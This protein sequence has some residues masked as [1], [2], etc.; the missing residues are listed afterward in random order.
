MKKKTWLSAAR[1]RVLAAPVTTTLAGSGAALLLAAACSG[2]PVVPDVVPA[3]TG[4]VSVDVAFGH[5]LMQPATASFHVWVLAPKE[6]FSASCSKL[7]ADEVDPYDKELE[8]LADEV[9]TDIQAAIEFSS[10]VGEGVVYVEGVNFS[11]EAVFA[12]CDSITVE[13]E[14]GASAEVTLI[15]AGSYD[16]DAAETEDGSPCDDGEFCTTGETCD[17]G[18]CGDGSARDCSTLAGDCSAG[19]CSESDGCMFEPQP[20]DTVCDDGLVCTA[21]DAC[22]DGQCIGAEV[23]CTG[24]VCGGAYCDEVSGGCVDGG[25]IP[26]GTPCDD[27]NVCTSASSCN[28]GT[29]NAQ[30]D[31]VLC[32][33]SDCAPDSDCDTGTGCA[34]NAAAATARLGYSCNDNPCMDYQYNYYPP[35]YGGEPS[36][37]YYATC[38]GLGTCV[39]GVPLPSGTTCNL[40]CQTGTCDGSGTC[41]ITGNRTDSTSCMGAHPTYSGTYYGQCMAGVCIY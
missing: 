32:P 35:G 2:V 11:G 26:Y 14:D 3:E 24:G 20:D 7:V 37:A 27:D 33:I 18:S 13:A 39:G 23:L 40:G 21:N 1:H 22:L 34:M 25:D 41:A 31:Y 6:G 16:C 38:D 30:V 15:A 19:T 12:G 10:E 8:V 29:C 17:N 4:D 36:E 28:Y 9:F 5:D